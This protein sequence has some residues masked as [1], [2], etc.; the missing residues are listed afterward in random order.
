MHCSFDRSFTQV[1][2]AKIPKKLMISNRIYENH[3][4]DLHRSTVLTPQLLRHELR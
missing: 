1:F 2:R 4:P 3:M